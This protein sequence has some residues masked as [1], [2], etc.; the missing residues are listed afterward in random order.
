LMCEYFV[1]VS[2]RTRLY[3]SV[4]SLVVVL[5]V[6]AKRHFLDDGWQLYLPVSIRIMFI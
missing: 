1:D 5:W 3:N 2:I 4:F 6:V